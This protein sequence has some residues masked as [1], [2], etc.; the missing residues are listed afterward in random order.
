MDIFLK[1]HC[2]LANKNNPII[3]DIGNSI[4]E[5]RFNTKLSKETKIK[6]VFISTDNFKF[7]SKKLSE[8]AITTALNN[9][10]KHKKK[11]EKDIDVSDCEL[12][13]ILGPVTIKGTLIPP[14]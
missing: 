4:D 8:N 13:L 5:N 2:P 12:A 11:S 3:V 6:Y 1:K 10:S 7:K 9:Y 14:S